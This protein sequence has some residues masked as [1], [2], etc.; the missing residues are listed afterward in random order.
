M[1]PNAPS[2]PIR[3]SALQ[4]LAGVRPEERAVLAWSALYFFL[5]MA[6]YFILRPIRDQM[7]VAGGVDNLAWL[8][9]G[10]LVAMLLLNPLFSTLVSRLPRRRFVAWSYRAL[11]TCLFGFYVAQVG[12][13]EASQVW[14]GRS[15]FIWVSVFNLFAVS[16]FW[17]VMSD[18]YRS[19]PSRRLYG[20]IA[21]G[22]SLGALVGG[23]ITSALVEAVGAPALLL[24]SLVMLELALW[25]MFAVHRQSGR[26]APA[27]ANGSEAVIGGSAIDGFR[28]ALRS[29]YLVGVCGYMLLYTIGSTFLYFLQ[30]QIVDA[31]ID[32]RAAQT[33]Y[34]ANVDIWV[35]GLTLVLQLFLTG[36]LM[37][38]LGV[39][40]TLAALPLISIVGFAALGAVP[41]LATVVIFTV[42]RRVT[43]YALS[44]PAREALFVP[45]GRSEKFKAK[46]LIDTV[47][48]RVGDQLGAWSN[49]VLA[50]LGLGIAGIAWTAAPL[51][52]VWLALSLWL[53]RRYRAMQSPD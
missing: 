15:F 21:A 17:A 42:A 45:L 30:A 14:V 29:P 34:F 27:S 41:V 48:Y 53:G 5:V 11:M 19:E 39:G 24:V 26:T 51:A 43:N 12:L 18:V 16:L 23:A 35:N 1:N 49:T 3:P 13:P 25:C 2:N 46:N 50:T 10:T 44:R 22:G 20:V 4:V 9:S 40:L 6:S 7:G 8:F 52:A 28:L 31:T 47:V 33:A 38:R 32:G 36:R 37:G